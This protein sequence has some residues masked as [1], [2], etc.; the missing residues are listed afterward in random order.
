MLRSISELGGYT[1]HATDGDIGRCQDF[2]FDDRSWVVRYMVARTARW[3]PGR[4]V[5]ISPVFLDEPDWASRRFPVRLTREQIEH[6]PPLEE[7]EPVSRRYEIDY[8]QHYALPFYWIGHELWGAFP[9]PAGVVHP[10]PTTPPPGAEIEEPPVEEGHLRSTDEVSGYHVAAT[11]AEVG[12][13][14]DFLV[15]DQTWALRYLVVDTRN[16][17]PGRKVLLSPQW[18]HAIQWVDE[19]VVA[20]LDSGSIRN[21]P[22]FDPSQPVNRRYE[23]E[24]YDYYGRPRYWK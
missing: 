8:H 5:V 19:K 9:D 21:S 7:H 18:I 22:E 12:H 3:L 10:V 16:W 24:L 4:K 1:L 13:V 23:V 2:L 14:A 11:D 15:D 20:D 6:C 17:L